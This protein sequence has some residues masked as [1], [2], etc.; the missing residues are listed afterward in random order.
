MNDSTDNLFPIRHVAQQTGVL[1][2][3]LRAWE[4]R[5]G[6]IKPTRTDKGH[7]LYSDEDIRRVR[8]IV[9]LIDTGIPVG[10]VK[11]ALASKA[12][13]PAAV[14]TSDWPGFQERLLKAARSL[15]TT[16]AI[17]TLRDA[18]GI[19]P[20]HLLADEL[21]RPCLMAIA[22]SEQEGRWAY[23]H[24]LTQAIAVYLEQRSRGLEPER[25]G[26]TLLIVSMPNVSGGEATERNL[27]AHIFEIMAREAGLDMRWLGQLP[28]LPALAE[29]IS[30]GNIRGVVLWEDGEPLGDWQSQ[31]YRFGLA[32]DG[33]FAMAGEFS[34][35]HHRQL[36][37]LQIQC[38]PAAFQDAIEL[39]RSW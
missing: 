25:S 38:L 33:P 29:L 28:G 35:R 23:R 10:Q 21:L 30:H 31:L 15:D 37:Q 6:L 16:S 2:V 3:T 5:Y 20:L 22:T 27:M 18:G 32:C 9:A 24:V 4:R 17:T 39:L 8:Q 1:P 34:L 13:T 11:S 7:R 14:A 12:A 26:Q 19:Y 36:E